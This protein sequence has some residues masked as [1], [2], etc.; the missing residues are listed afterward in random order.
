MES[1]F[2]YYTTFSPILPEI[3]IFLFLTFQITY[4]VFFSNHISFGH[5]TLGPS[6]NALL[7]IFLSGL[8]VNFFSSPDPSYESFNS[9]LSIIWSSLL[10]RGSMIF[11]SAII[12]LISFGYLNLRS[13]YQY[14]FSL[15]L[16]F[17]IAGLSVLA[18]TNDVLTIFIVLE[19][20]GLAFYLLATFYW[21]SEFNTEAGLKYFVLGSFSSCLLLFGFSLI[22]TALGSISFE[23][24]QLLLNHQHYFSMTLFGLFFVLTAFLFKIGAAP[25][26]MW[27]CDVYEGSLTPVTLFFATVPKIIIF[28]VLLKLLFSVFSTENISW[29]FFCQM[30]GFFSVGLA[31]I[32]ALFQ[33]KTKRLLAFSAVSHSG[34]LLL[35]ASCFSFFSLKSIFFYLLVYIFMNISV[36]SI[37]LATTRSQI[38][39]Y[40]IHWAYFFNRNA[41]LGITFSILLLSLAGIPPLSGFYSKLL[42]MLSLI[43]QSQYLIA[44]LTAI[45]SCVACY[46]YIRLIKIFFFGT[47]VEGVWI[48]VQSR[49]LEF[50][51][52][53]FSTIVVFLLGFSDFFLLLSNL[54]AMFLI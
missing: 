20:Q 30:V 16:L 49:F 13:I 4:L 54:F 39:K 5:I 27:L 32:A 10:V 42:I 28:Y 34:F 36:F 3:L 40:L 43:Y 9:H 22:Y 46:Y 41:V 44:L 35:A 2:I 24:I 7:V 29:S 38:F 48:S 51:I 31:S 1:L 53:I 47:N 26:H 50:S 19:L 8:L 37:V 25:F 52:A 17:S 18:L 12:V 23:T 15:L 21:S 11:T 33:K 6:A 14:E 45:I